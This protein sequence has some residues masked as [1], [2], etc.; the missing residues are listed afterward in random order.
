VDASDIA[1][2]E[3][4]L[5]VSQHHLQRATMLHRNEWQ[6]AIVLWTAIGA[7]TVT[8]AAN[9]ESIFPLPAAGMLVIIAFYVIVGVA[10]L[11]GFCRA[12]YKSLTE[13]RSRYRYFQN[14]AME[15]ISLNGDDLILERGLHPTSSEKKLSSFEYSQTW[16]FKMISTYLAQTASLCTIGYLEHRH[17][18]ESMGF[19]FSILIW[20][21]L[22]ILI[23]GVALGYGAWFKT[24]TLPEGSE[25]EPR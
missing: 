17:N 25:S 22:G 9:A 16:R 6:I 23:A 2:A 8:T 21:V 12:N 11:Y 7:A 13:E 20:V 3:A 14:R 1:R 24:T 4:Y 15:I 5:K 18:Q 19:L 10:Y